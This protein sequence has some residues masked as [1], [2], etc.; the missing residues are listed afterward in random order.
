M[1]ET[2][3]KKMKNIGSVLGMVGLVSVLCESVRQQA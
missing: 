2:E 1:H 3:G